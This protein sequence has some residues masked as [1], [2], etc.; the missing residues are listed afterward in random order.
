MNGECNLKLVIENVLK[1]NVYST[2]VKVEDLTAEDLELFSDY[3]EQ[4]VD[5]SAKVE[6]EVTTEVDNGDGTTTP[7]TTTVSLINEGTKYK[8]FPKDF[9]LTRSFSAKQY[10]EDTEFLANEYAL[11]IEE[12]IKLL[13]QGLRTKGDNFTSVRETLI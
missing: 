11:Q 5:V 13:V 4:Y 2:T 1:D 6:K 12:K 3:G 10:G 7:T 9:P 8:V